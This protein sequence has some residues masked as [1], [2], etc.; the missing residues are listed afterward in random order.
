[1]TTE[2]WFW[3]MSWC[4]KLRA[5]PANPYFWNR[6]GEEYIKHLKANV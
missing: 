4:K 3:R 6:A 1:M 5:A 2:K